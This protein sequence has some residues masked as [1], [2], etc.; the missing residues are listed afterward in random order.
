[1]IFMAPSVI[2]VYNRFINGVDRVDQLRST[3][4]NR[5]DSFYVALRHCYN[6]C[7]CTDVTRQKLAQ[8]CL[9]E[10][11][12]RQRVHREEKRQ[13]V[14][15]KG[16]LDAD[17]SVHIITPNLTKHSKGNLKCYYRG[18]EVK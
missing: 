2:T 3:N 11:A 7:I 12:R 16:V 9:D 18:Q 14:V 6:Q 8:L 17:T 13:R 15:L 10:A 5:N 1:M 4:P